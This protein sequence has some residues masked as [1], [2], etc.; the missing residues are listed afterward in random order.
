[1]KTDIKLKDIS[2]IAREFLKKLLKFFEIDI[3]I[4]IPFNL[5]ETYLR[6]NE[7]LI[8]SEKEFIVSNPS[9]N[10]F[11]EN[12]N[13]ES[14]YLFFN[15]DS[16]YTIKISLPNKIE[17]EDED[18]KIISATVIKSSKRPVN[19]ESNLDSDK[20]TKDKTISDKSSLGK[21]MTMKLNSQE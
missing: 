7:A 11:Q 9:T 5:N 12:N 3:I 13:L 20:N 21:T 6:L 17:N 14:M 1:M 19:D 2:L 18:E 4:K 15:T 8:I 10:K 16:K